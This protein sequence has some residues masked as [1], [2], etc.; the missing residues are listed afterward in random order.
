MTASEFDL[1]PTTIETEDAQGDPY[2]FAEAYAA[3][4]AAELR[5]E[6][7]RLKIQLTDLLPDISHAMLTEL[8]ITW[9]AT[10]DG[11]LRTVHYLNVRA[12][13]AEAERD[14]LMEAALTPPSNK[15]KP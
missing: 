9:S 13:K 2:G 7:E 15:E 8:G 6:I 10:I 14:R 12:E 1:L 4:V 11:G 5:Q 3:H